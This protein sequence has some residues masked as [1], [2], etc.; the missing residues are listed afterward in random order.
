MYQI[1]EVGTDLIVTVSMVHFI[2]LQ[3]RGSVQGP[4]GREDAYAEPDPT[5]CRLFR[6][7]LHTPL[8]SLVTPNIYLFC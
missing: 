8:V 5:R 3:V 2:K 1:V 4:S 6:T 7:Q